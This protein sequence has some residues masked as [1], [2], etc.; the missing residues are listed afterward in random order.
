MRKK[1]EANL[2]LI[3]FLNHLECVYVFEKNEKKNS[4]IMFPEWE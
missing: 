3:R 4:E 1:I 2:V